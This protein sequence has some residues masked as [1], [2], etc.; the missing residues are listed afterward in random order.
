MMILGEILNFAAYSFVEGPYDAPFPLAPV[1][2]LPGFL[3]SHRS[4][5]FAMNQMACC[6]S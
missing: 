6:T 5:E 1:T 2:G 3:R 4:G